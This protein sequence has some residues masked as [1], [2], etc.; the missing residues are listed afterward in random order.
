MQQ[1]T[2]LVAQFDQLDPGAARTAVQN[3]WNNTIKGMW[4]TAKLLG[5]V[6][7]DKLFDQ[8]GNEDGVV[9]SSLAHWAQDDLQISAPTVSKMLKAVSFLETLPPEK[10]SQFQQLSLYRVYDVIELAK[11]D[12]DGAFEIASSPRSDG[13]VRQAVKEE[14]PDQHHD[15]SGFNTTKFQMTNDEARQL[16]R[17]MNAIRHWMRET[18]PNDGTVLAMLAQEFESRFVPDPEQ[19]AYAPELTEHVQEE[20][21][22][23][24]CRCI[25]CGAWY[26]IQRHHAVPRSHKIE[27]KNPDDLDW[28]CVWLCEQHH[29]KV[30]RNE[31]GTWRKHLDRWMKKHEWL[32]V[33]VNEWLDGRTLGAT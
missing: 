2:D 15:T 4:L 3:V 12:A 9:Y 19:A 7:R 29:G 21:L 23:G 20:I 31:E 26:P 11:N 32:E 10:Q 5:V 17:G 28:P 6:K 22:S 18:T 25:D 13:Q 33:Q 8:W 27:G 30:T 24:H 16:D 14:Q 1:S